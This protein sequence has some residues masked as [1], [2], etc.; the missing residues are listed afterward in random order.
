MG[1]PEAKVSGEYIS[2]TRLT[3]PRLAIRTNLSQKIN[4][5]SA[6]FEYDGACIFY[7]GDSAASPL[8]PGTGGSYVWS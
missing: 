8:E 4:H 7:L 2:N 5:F 6:R 3:D 1:D